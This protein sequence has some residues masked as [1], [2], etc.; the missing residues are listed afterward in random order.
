METPSNLIPLA[1]G[2]LGVVTQRYAGLRP[3]QVCTRPAAGAA[4][5][6]LESNA[7]AGRGEPRLNPYVFLPALKSL[8]DF[9]PQCVGAGSGREASSPRQAVGPVVSFKR[10]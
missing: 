9:R 5:D 6:H 4:L 8:M 10:N 3:F 7:P 2:L 1:G